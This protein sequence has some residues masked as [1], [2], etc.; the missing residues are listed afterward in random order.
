MQLDIPFWYLAS[1]LLIAF[2]GTFTLRALP[3]AILEP[4]R[5]SQFVRV[6]AVWMPAGILVLLA[7][8]TFKS[9]LAEEPGSIIHLLIASAVTIA[10]HLF[11]GRRTLVS[12]AAGTLAFV[13]LVNFF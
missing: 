12:V 3:F 8:A 2:A 10:V 13:L 7:L 4:L 11:G 9:T 1:V 5:K 6:M